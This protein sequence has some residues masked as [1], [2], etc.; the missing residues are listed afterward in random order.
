M[1]IMLLSLL[2]AI[3]PDDFINSIREQ[4]AAK[5]ESMLAAEPSLVDATNAKGRSVTT[6]ALFTIVNN[7]SFIPPKKNRV[8]QVILARKPKLD[9]WL[10]AALGS[11]TEL[12]KMLKPELVPTLVNAPN[13]FGWSPLHLAAFVGNVDNVK[14]LLD[15]GADIRLRAK[16]K[17]HNTPLLIA[18]L[19]GHVDTVRLLLDRGADIFDRQAEGTA[20]LHHAAL[21]GDL[22]MVKL[23][24]E[25]GAELNSRE[26][27]GRTPVDE[28]LRGKHEDV[29]EYLRSKG[30][31]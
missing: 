16:T 27:N 26:D 24:L 10:T 1:N 3:A 17:F 28:A 21:S 30:G 29:A 15:R 22:E 31:K 11:S 12:S 8:L 2:L 4:D 23:L 25:R 5:V 19:T 7:E 6:V 20:A 18:L 13:D 9:L 14:L